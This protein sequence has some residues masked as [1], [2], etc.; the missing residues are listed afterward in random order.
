MTSWINL[1]EIATD[2]EGEEPATIIPDP[3]HMDRVTLLYSDGSLA[4]LYCEDGIWHFA[5]APSYTR[6]AG[7]C[8]GGEGA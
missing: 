1:W 2:V 5:E 6:N 8:V 3:E 7:T 4:G